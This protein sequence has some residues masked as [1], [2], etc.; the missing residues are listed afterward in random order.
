MGAVELGSL[1]ANGTT[2]I[3]EFLADILPVQ[4]KP[5]SSDDVKFGDEALSTLWLSGGGSE[6]GRSRL[7]RVV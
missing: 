6:P 7:G 2:A 1:T 4:R 3:P 5:P